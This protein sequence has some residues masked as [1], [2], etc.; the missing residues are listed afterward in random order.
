MGGK[1]VAGWIAG[2]DGVVI[3]VEALGRA[4]GAGKGFRTG[5]NIGNGHGMQGFR[6]REKPAGVKRVDSNGR[7][8]NAYILGIH[9]M[10]HHLILSVT[11]IVKSSNL[12]RVRVGL[13]ADLGIFN[14]AVNS[15]SRDHTLRIQL[16][17]H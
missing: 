5:E 4:T 1:E 7:H 12:A 9:Y 2:E 10:S 11:P 8:Y 14:I 15:A 13:V 16:P 17:T 6:P 3:G